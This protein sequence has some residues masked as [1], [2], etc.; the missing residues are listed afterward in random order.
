MSDC[1]FCKIVN[2]EA[3]SKKVYEDEK[4]LA[5]LDINP[6]APVHILLIPKKHIAS[7]L[8]VTEVDAEVIGHIFVV[9]AKLAKELGVAENGYRIITNVGQHG[10][11]T[12]SHLH[13]QLIG[14]KQLS[15]TL[16]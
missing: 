9:A 4:M 6:L 7:A 16:D 2:G 14:G 15:T 3:P 11:Q 12:V 8:E 10:G 13:F 5:F 1:I